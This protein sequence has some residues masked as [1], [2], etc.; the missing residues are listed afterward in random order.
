MTNKLLLLGAITAGILG[1]VSADAATLATEGFVRGGVASAIATANTYTDTEIDKLEI[2]SITGLATETYVD[3]AIE[4]MATETYVDDAID[5]IEFPTLPTLATV[6]TTGAYSDLS[7]T[8]TLG[9][10]AAMDA[11]AFVQTET[12]PVAMEALDAKANLAATVP[13]GQGGYIAIVN[14]SGQYTRG[15]AKIENLVTTGALNT[16]LAGKADTTFV[17]SGPLDTSAQNLGAAVNEL[18]TEIS[19]AQGKISGPAGQVLVG[20]GDGFTWMATTGDTYTAE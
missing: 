2:P 7:G 15:I 3:N 8:P 6:A 18:H 10:A 4:D 9:T 1:T 12:D 17:G 20:T 5:N 13:E 19:A 16:G 11:T 14:E